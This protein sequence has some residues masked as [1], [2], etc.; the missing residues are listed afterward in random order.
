[1]ILPTLL[2]SGFMDTLNKDIARTR[3]DLNE[4]NGGKT[5]SF[6]KGLIIGVVFMS[7]L[8]GIILYCQKPVSINN[9]TSPL[10]DRAQTQ[11]QS[12]P[13]SLT[14]SRLDDKEI[15]KEND[16][17]TCKDCK[18]RPVRQF[19]ARKCAKCISRR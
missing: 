2:I 8:V 19:G 14:G 6:M 3:D 16:L 5:G 15:D 1:M 4:C 7:V 18:S 11:L 12:L 9:S 17:P 10:P 13:S